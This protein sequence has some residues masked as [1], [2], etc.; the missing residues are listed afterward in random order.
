MVK[1]KAIQLSKCGDFIASKGW[2]DKFKV[3]YGLEIAKEQKGRISSQMKIER[4]RKQMEAISNNY[5][6][7]SEKLEDESESE[8]KEEGFE[9]FNQNSSSGNQSH[10]DEDED[11]DE[12]CILSNMS[13]SNSNSIFSSD[14]KT[15][16]GDTSDR[17]QISLGEKPQPSKK[18]I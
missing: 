7:L 2:L 14:E 18:K 5:C 4:Q 11:E 3:R 1:D 8:K 16:E 6:S 15:G 10:S 9:T 17:D 12:E 13:N